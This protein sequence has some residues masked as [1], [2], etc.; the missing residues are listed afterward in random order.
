M[1]G[2]FAR[3]N[4]KPDVWEAPDGKDSNINGL[5]KL[6]VIIS[7]HEQSEL[8]SIEVNV[9]RDFPTIGKETI[10]EEDYD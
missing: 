2:L 3:I 9:I 8:N 5:A 7:N 6:L 1:A 10:K 4:A